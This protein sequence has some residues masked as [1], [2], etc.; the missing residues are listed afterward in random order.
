MM[1]EDNRQ[2]NLLGPAESGVPGAVEHVQIIQPNTDLTTPN[3]PSV[4][5]HYLWIIRRH[6]WKIVT[7]VVASVAATVISSSRLTP[8]YESTA[9]IDID[10]QMPAAVLGADAARQLNDSDQFLT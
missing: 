8:I 5:G 1:N 6:K 2:R 10:R 4:L 9:T 7:F 3:D